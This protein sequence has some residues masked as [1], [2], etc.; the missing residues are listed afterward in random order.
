[1]KTK[2]AV[3][4]LAIS[5]TSPSSYAATEYSKIRKDINVMSQVIKGAF[6]DEA[7]CRRCG[8]SVEGSYLAEQGAVFLIS[9]SRSYLRYTDP[10]DGNMDHRFDNWEFTS[11]D[12]LA[13][14]PGMV[15]EIL[16]DIEIDIDGAR[17]YGTR[18]RDDRIIDRESRSRLRDI[19][20]ER[21]HLEE[22][23]R[24]IEIELI[25]AEEDER[26]EQEERLAEI[27]EQIKTLDEKR[28]KLDELFDQR[29]VAYEQRRKEEQEKVNN[30]QQ[31]RLIQL[32]DLVLG[33]FCDYGA[34]LIGVPDDQH[35]TVVLENVVRVRSNSES[36][37]FVFNKKDLSA[38]Q[39]DDN[40]TD[41]LRERS[42]VYNF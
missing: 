37:I 12:D 20:R 21:R 9:P 7:D 26:Q 18:F 17:H 1:M 14:I 30:R 19:S 5:F 16:E 28:K 22:E 35:V 41:K 3:L 4:I 33:T 39:G 10:G 29:R 38:C 13:E 34:N 31:Q 2:Y 36:R 15:S 40:G 24:D 23:M 25:H 6:E 32:E 11:M 27:G 8:T 42:I